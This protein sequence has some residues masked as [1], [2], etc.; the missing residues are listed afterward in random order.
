MF[1]P[2]MYY[3]LDNACA[4]LEAA[5]EVQEL[6][7]AAGIAVDILTEAEYFELGPGSTA[8]GRQRLRDL[9][10]CITKRTLQ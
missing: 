6:Y 5:V 7:Q 1:G 2:N 10:Q 3:V 8:L 9:V 4:T